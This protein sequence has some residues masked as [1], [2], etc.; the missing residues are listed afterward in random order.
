MTK[1]LVAGTICASLITA[2]AALPALAD[3]ATVIDHQNQCQTSG[4]VT[5][6]LTEHAVFNNTIAGSSGNQSVQLQGT[7]TITI[8]F[9]GNLVATIED[10][11]HFH[12]VYK[13]GVLHEISEH[14]PDCVSVNGQSVKSNIDYHQVDGKV[15]YD[16]FGIALAASC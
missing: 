1:T 16:R 3:G 12:A 6:C 15:Q 2:A 10:G 13:D 8:Y 9:S 5:E 14:D 11:Q 7:A 4:P